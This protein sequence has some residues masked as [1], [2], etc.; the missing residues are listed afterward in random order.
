MQLFDFYYLNIDLDHFS[1]L[2]N[3]K[4]VAMTL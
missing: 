2:S 1:W 4:R 3:Q